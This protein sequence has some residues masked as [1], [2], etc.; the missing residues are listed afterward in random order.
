[1]SSSQPPQ[2]SQQFGPPAHQPPEPPKQGFR[3]RHPKTFWTLT[4]LAG[5]FVASIVGSIV[6]PSKDDAG[7]A[8]AQ[9]TSHSGTGKKAVSR[10]AAPA[11]DPA[12]GVGD[13]VRD[14]KFAFTVHK[15]KCGVAHVGNEYIGADAQGQ[16]CLVTLTVE[17]IGS[18]PQTLFSSNQKGYIG[19]TEYAVDDTATL[20]SA[21]AGDSPWLKDINPGNALT[22]TIVFDIPQGAELS[23]LELHDSAF[24]GG[25]EVRL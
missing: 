16:F 20:Y 11:P 14:G 24:S 19:D 13:E 4:I 18:E 15:V 1:M 7:S 10:R 9:A 12:A 23:K 3:R 6:S 22:G 17:N 5:L 21:S 25:A 2:W 8:T